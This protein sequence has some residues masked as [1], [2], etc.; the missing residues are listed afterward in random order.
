MTGAEGQGTGSTHACASGLQW[1][2]IDM[3]GT[4]ARRR[5]TL[6]STP[7]LSSTA[8]R[9][10]AVSGSHLRGSRDGA[11]SLLGVCAACHHSSAPDSCVVMPGA[12]WR[13]DWF[14]PRWPAYRP[15][16]RSAGSGDRPSPLVGCT[17]PTR[18]H[19]QV[20]ALPPAVRQGAQQAAQRPEGWQGC[21]RQLQRLLALYAAGMFAGRWRQRP[22]SHGGWHAAAVAGRKAGFVELL[23]QSG[24]APMVYQREGTAAAVA[25]LPVHV[26]DSASTP[27]CNEFEP[28]SP[29]P[30]CKSA[31]A[32]RSTCNKQPL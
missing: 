29:T 23:C 10:G 30:A 27:A 14:C 20:A 18:R 6:L 17:M 4:W 1:A 28:R 7:P 21:S 24:K 19:A 16:T 32:P 13:N 5:A 8:T 26:S 3:L 31:F 2:H 22:C 9:S 12:A 11:D 25:C 15:L